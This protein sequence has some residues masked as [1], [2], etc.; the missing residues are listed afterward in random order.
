MC[1]VAVHV[2]VLVVVVGVGVVVAVRVGGVVGCVDVVSVV[3]DIVAAAAVVDRCVRFQHVSL[4]HVQRL[5]DHI[6]ILRVVTGVK[7]YMFSNPCS[8]NS[9][10]F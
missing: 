9:V 5:P 1:V 6:D 8:S 3:A 10:L 2:C 4:E 7:T